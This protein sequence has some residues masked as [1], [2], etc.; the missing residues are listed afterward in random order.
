MEVV[1]LIH[2]MLWLVKTLLKTTG[3]QK[4]VASAF[5]EYFSASASLR[6]GE[7]E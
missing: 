5:L 7:Y 2:S 6:H 3:Q 4:L 1:G